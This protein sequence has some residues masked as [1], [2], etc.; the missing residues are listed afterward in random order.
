MTKNNVAQSTHIKHVI[1]KPNGNTAKHIEICC[2]MIYVKRHDI[3]SMSYLKSLK[4]HD[5]VLLALYTLKPLDVEK[6]I[7]INCTNRTNRMM[8]TS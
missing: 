2:S 6:I 3:T 5:I 4:R 7:L 8:K 1:A